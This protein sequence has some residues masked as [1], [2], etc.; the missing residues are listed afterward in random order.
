[1]PPQ[2]VDNRK[3]TLEIACVAPGGDGSPVNKHTTNVQTVNHGGFPR[4][5]SLPISSSLWGE[6]GGSA[7][8]QKPRE[9]ASYGQTAAMIAPTRHHIAG[10]SPVRFPCKPACLARSDST[11][12]SFHF[13]EPP[14]CNVSI[15][16]RVLG[17]CVCVRDSWSVRL[18]PFR[19]VLLKPFQHNVTGI[20][21]S[22]MRL[23]KNICII[24]LW[25]RTLLLEIDE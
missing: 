11:N 16:A 17:V 6:E 19:G 12:P 13:F 14:R 25:R 7:Q 9:D 8:H 3:Y 20:S 21:K 22:T 15:K 5:K 18:L 2:L 1:M 10:S 24:F 4:R 23:Y